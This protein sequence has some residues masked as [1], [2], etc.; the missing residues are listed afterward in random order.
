MKKR[1]PLTLLFCL[2]L[3]L[4]LSSCRIKEG[5]VGQNKPDGEKTLEYD[6][7]L[8]F[9]GR[10][11]TYTGDGED[12]EVSDDIITVKASGIY[13][14]SGEL[15]EGRL[16]LRGSDVFLVLDGVT[17]NSSYGA[18][19]E[20]DGALTL[21]SSENSVNIFSS[22]QYTDKDSPFPS[23]S[24]ISKGVLKL[25]GE[26]LTVIDTEA[27]AAI[28]SLTDANVS[29]GRVNLKAQK[30][31]MWARDDIS[32]SG[33]Q[34][35]S[36]SADA[37]IYAGGGELSSGK[38][39]ISGGTL[40]VISQSIGLYA[41]KEINISGGSGTFDC[42]TVYKCDREKINISETNTAFPKYEK[43]E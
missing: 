20:A 14:L 37:G 31:G 39:H 18:V 4:C 3:C 28:L 10:R 11:Y 29:G 35:T 21:S 41:Q 1:R 13:R 25:C 22:K 7:E 9:E 42:K 6:G 40:A 5:D 30:Y 34:L 33:G 23:A 12:I 43:S 8:L 24:V 26:G 32:L 36:S 38:L 15:T 17:L 19:I 27:D 16:R 2:F